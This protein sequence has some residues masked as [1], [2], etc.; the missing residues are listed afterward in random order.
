MA[1]G[2]LNV[3][4]GVVS[5]DASGNFTVDTGLIADGASVFNETGVDVDFRIESDDNANMFFVDGGEDRVGIGTATPSSALDVRGTVQV[6]VAG[7]G[8]DVYFYGDTSGKHLLWDQ[9][10]DEL[11]FATS[12]K[13]SFHDAA[14]GENILAS[15]DGHLEVNAGTTLDIT[16]PTVDINASTLVQIDGPVSV[17]VDDTGHDVIFYGAAAGARMYWAQGNNRLELHGASA[18]AAGSS[19]SLVFATLQ[20][21]VE[22]GDIIGRMDFE[23]PSVGAAGDSRLT[24]SSIWAEADATFSSTVNQC[25]LVFATSASEVATEKMRITS[26]GSV[27]IGTSAPD[28]PLH[29]ATATVN[30]GQIIQGSYN[31]NANPYLSIRK[32]NGTIASPTAITSGHYAGLIRFD[33]YDGNSWHTPAD[34]VCVTSGTVADGRVAGNLTFRTSPDSAADQSERMRITSAGY[35]GIGTTAPA[36]QIHSI[37]ASGGW[38]FSDLGAND[39]FIIMEESGNNSNNGIRIRKKYSGTGVLPADRYIGDISFQGWD[40]DTWRNAAL[41]EVGLTGTPGND[42]MPGWFKL[43]TNTGSTGTTQRLLVAHTGMMTF[44]TDG[45]QSRGWIFQNMGDH[46]NYGGI[47]VRAGANDQSGTTIWFEADDSGGQGVGVLKSISGTFQLADTSD[48][49][50][51][52]NIVN[53]AIEGLNTVNAM[54]VRDFV[55]KNNNTLCSAGF[56]ANELVDAFAPAVDG[57]PDAM[58]TIVDQEGIYYQEH[59]DIPVGK[60]KGDV[61]IAETTKEVIEAMT[62]SRERLVPVLVKAIQELS[63]KVTALENA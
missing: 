7:T 48:V 14:G 32:S 47:N 4:G 2:I 21:G 18:D 5:V 60:F 25:E 63:A 19:G 53:T 49:R 34:I 55:W 33:A 61:K 39:K 56:I 16:A 38:I 41:I 57:E 31:N 28:G 62:V 45:T 23:A 17:G 50:L 20:T 30:V 15:A 29:L 6:G 1:K 58:K 59:D 36:A 11:L 13:L 42:T 24:C 12:T 54:K 51:K 44:T 10:G 27:G 26:D 3:G 40:G 9:S 37:T 8:H 35:I 46:A 43:G 52:K 22:D